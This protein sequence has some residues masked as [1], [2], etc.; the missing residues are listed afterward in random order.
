[1][2]GERAGVS[3]AAPLGGRTVSGPLR[4]WIAP[5]RGLLLLGVLLDL[6]AVAATIGQA[7]ALSQIVE[8]VLLHA[9]GLASVGGPAALLIAL[10]LVRAGLLWVREV[11]GQ[12][13]AVGLASRLRRRLAAHLLRLGP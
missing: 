9:Q 1:M 2:R 7:A 4:A 11:A 3:R 6:G 10:A 13:A 5:V 12:Q 8:P